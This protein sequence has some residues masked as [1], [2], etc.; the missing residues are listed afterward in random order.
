MANYKVQAEVSVMAEKQIEA[1]SL[2]DALAKAHKLKFEDLFWHRTSVTDWKDARRI[3]IIG[4][5]EP[6][7]TR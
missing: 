5:T 2:E 3:K 7:V 1:S 4:A 6:K